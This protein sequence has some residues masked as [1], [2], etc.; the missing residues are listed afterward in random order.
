[1][2]VGKAE[3][4]RIERG[5]ESVQDNGRAQRQRVGTKQCMLLGDLFELT[6]RG[7]EAD[8]LGEVFGS[9]EY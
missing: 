1:M 3:L 7:T 6:W 4:G 8:E 5:P 9:T 2:R